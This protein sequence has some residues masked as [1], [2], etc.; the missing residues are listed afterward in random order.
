[1]AKKG[2]GK[3]KGKGKKKKAPEPEP[4]PPPPVNPIRILKKNGFAI[5]YDSEDPPKPKT[6]VV[7]LSGDLNEAR[8]FGIRI[9]EDCRIRHE[10]SS[11]R[12][13]LHST[14]HPHS[15]PAVADQKPAPPPPA[16]AAGEGRPQRGGP[17][18]RQRHHRCE[19]Q[20]DLRTE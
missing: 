9:S 19:R 17:T 15:L 18:G 11:V 14:A 4:E 16:A 2:K 12:R 13:L 3:G 8:G 5:M 10:P 20:A 1:M 6:Y 7:K